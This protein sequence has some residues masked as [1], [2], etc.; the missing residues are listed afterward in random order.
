MGEAE[1][2]RPASVL[3]VFLDVVYDLRLCKEISGCVHLGCKAIFLHLFIG[4]RV[5][6]V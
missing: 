5:L 2:M 4:D 6:S 1:Q 3:N